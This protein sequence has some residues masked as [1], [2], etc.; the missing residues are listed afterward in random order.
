MATQHHHHHH[1]WIAQS[2]NIPTALTSDSPAQINI[3]QLRLNLGCSF[4]LQPNRK[5]VRRCMAML[6]ACLFAWYERYL[7]YIWKHWLSLS[8]K[9]VLAWYAWTYLFLP[10]HT[11]LLGKS[12]GIHSSCSY[13][14]HA[15]TTLM[16]FGRFVPNTVARMRFALSQISVLA[17]PITVDWKT[18]YVEPFHETT[19]TTRSMGVTTI[20]TTTAAPGCHVEYFSYDMKD[21]L[22]EQL[23]RETNVY[24]ANYVH[25][26]LSNNPTVVQGAFV[27]IHDNNHKDGST[28]SRNRPVILWLYGGAFLAGDVE[29]NLEHAKYVGMAVGC[30]VMVP[31]YRL[32]P[33]VPHLNDQLW[34]TTLAYR[35]V[36]QV[37]N[38]APHQIFLWGISSGAGLAI[39]LMQNASWMMQQHV[40][41]R[42]KTNGTNKTSQKERDDDGNDDES[43]CR[44][45]VIPSMV[46]PL[47]AHLQPTTLQP[48]TSTVNDSST[49]ST[50]VAMGVVL[51]CPFVDYTTPQVGGSFLEYAQ[52]DLIVN[53]S[54]LE[55]GLPYLD[56][57]LGKDDA[58]R[59]HAS[60]LYGTYPKHVTLPPVCVIVSE[61]ETVYDQ[62]MQ[63]V[64][65][66]QENH[67]P[68]TVGVWKYM[69][70]V[71]CM[72]YA[73]LPEGNEAMQFCLQW[74]IQ[75]K[76]EGQQ[77]GN[78]KTS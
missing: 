37:R 14:F 74:I 64:Q 22:L 60:P 17:R 58:P 36:T 9:K 26:L 7:F 73:Y 32:I 72:I 46:Q 42:T 70:H 6:N 77:N 24:V 16:Y 44:Q 35:Y 25:D 66:L 50:A 78:N 31:H 18:N 29:G 62:S 33:D 38:V 3:Q 69:F 11:L 4:L 1:C 68:V 57:V 76:E 15:L 28:S 34:D 43:Y 40:V 59:R 52:H 67:V 65:A 23:S 27:H 45:Q 13:E 48:T 53:Q 20:T 41:V 61:H 10:L 75:Q 2:P 5:G 39:R 54:V 12:T 71:F 51:L 55:V 47:L 56:Q 49:T 30:H 21:K 8:V 63:L 19:T